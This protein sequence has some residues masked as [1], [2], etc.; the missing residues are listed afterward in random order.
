LANVSK[1]IKNFDYP[2]LTSVTVEETPAIDGNAWII[3]TTLVE[4]SVPLKDD[5][6]THLLIY[7]LLDTNSNLERLI[8]VFPVKLDVYKS[9]LEPTNFG[10]DRPVSL[11]Y[12]GYLLALSKGAMRGKRV[13]W[14]RQ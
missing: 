10:N 12:N 7:S 4:F 6:N 1:E 5:E 2:K 14:R 8:T 9:L 13:L 3:R 11:R